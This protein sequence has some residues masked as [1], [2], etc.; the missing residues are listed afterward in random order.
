MEFI[1]GM[2]QMVGIE[3]QEEQ[4]IFPL[5]NQ[6]THS[7]QIPMETFIG[8]TSFLL[9]KKIFLQP[10]GNKKEASQLLI[11]VLV[12]ERFGPQ[13]LIKE[14]IKGS[15]H[16]GSENQELLSE[17]LLMVR[18]ILMLLTKDMVFTNGTTPQITGH[19]CQELLGMLE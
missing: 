17:L 3:L 15:T 13:D 5:E 12:A 8:P 1:D 7:F 18:E 14:F 11:L 19:N 16:N 2:D 6:E 10:I 9:L 4:Q